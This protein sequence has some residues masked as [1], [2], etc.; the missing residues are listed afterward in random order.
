VVAFSEGGLP[1]SGTGYFYADNV[2]VE[3]PECATMDLND[4][5]FLD[6][7]DVEKFADDWLFC[8]RSPAGECLM[9]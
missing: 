4:D 1:N 9:P 2:K 5:C 3:G 7:L 6:W 8:N